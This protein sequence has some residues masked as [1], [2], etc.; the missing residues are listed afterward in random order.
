MSQWICLQRM[1]SST[2][3]PVN[4][5][6]SDRAEETRAPAAEDVTAWFELVDVTGASGVEIALE[7]VDQIWDVTEVGAG[8]MAF[9]VFCRVVVAVTPL[10]EADAEAGQDL[11]AELTLRNLGGYA[12]TLSYPLRVVG[13]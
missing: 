9:R 8:G 4:A 2:V 13:R 10:E 5:A 3:V 7:G 11:T 6:L 12:F 1:P